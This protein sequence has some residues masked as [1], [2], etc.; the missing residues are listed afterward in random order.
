MGVHAVFQARA[1]VAIPILGVGGIRSAR[2]A[3]QYLLAG[4]TL[5]QIGTASFADPRA[6]L[7]V[8]SGLKRLAPQLAVS[9][10]REL[11]GAGRIFEET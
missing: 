10:V 6:A 2:D 5:V 9:D 11:I 3:V 7:R 4:A 8:L 1:R